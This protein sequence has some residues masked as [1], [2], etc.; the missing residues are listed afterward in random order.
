MDEVVGGAVG[1]PG[2]SRGKGRTCLPANERRRALQQQ[3]VHAHL[4]AGLG[5]EGGGA[6]DVRAVLRPSVFDQHGEHLGQQRTIQLNLP[7][8]MQAG[9]QAVKVKAQAGPQPIRPRQVQHCGNLPSRVVVQTRVQTRATP[10]NQ[11]T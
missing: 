8:K 1:I 10:A 6:A 5:K 7:V 9:P 2:S 4:L 11:P 3:A